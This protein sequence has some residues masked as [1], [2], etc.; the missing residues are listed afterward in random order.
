MTATP[1]RPLRLSVSARGEA[2][3]KVSWLELFFDLIFV[4]AVA[5]VAEPLAHD[6]TPAGLGR[7]AVL[8]ALIWWAWVGYTSFAT[9]FEGDAGVQRGLTLLQMFVVA[10]LA[11]NAS[12]ELDSRSAAGCAAAYAVL[13]LLLVAQYLRARD[14]MEARPLTGRYVVGHGVAALVFLC[15]AL[16][17]APLRYALWAIAFAADLGTP[18]LALP[19][20]VR[21]PSHSE[22]L[23]ERFGLFTL[24]LLGEAVVAVM[25]GMKSH[26]AWRPEA[27]AS[28][29]L[30]MGLLF[31]IW[32]WYFHGARAAA[33]RPIRSRRDSVRA[34]VWTYVH[35]PLYLGIVVLGVG[36]E[37]A[38]EA[39]SRS[40]V[41]GADAMIVL[42][43]VALIVVSMA[44]LTAVSGRAHAIAG[45]VR[46]AAA[47]FVATLAVALSGALTSP[48][49]LVAT[50]AAVCGLQMASLRARYGHDDASSGP[51]AH[52]TASAPAL[53]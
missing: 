6:Y 5:Q 19:H 8:L 35:Y 17:E 11:A 53:R 49:L 12:D 25:H 34:H 23:P 39:A 15:S 50:A 4:A 33:E 41:H 3:R 30:G 43:A 13:R 16:V 40:P 38:V 1:R 44:C 32:W 2:A 45:L 36:V 31:A 10:A 37:R 21:V 22:H 51:P 52:T 42:G 9:R 14:V 26:D 28:A 29:F 27:A 20:T 24:I 47:A 48:L 18:W 7:V 46:P